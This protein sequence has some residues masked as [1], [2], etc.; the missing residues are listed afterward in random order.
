ML[1][2]S[3]INGMESRQLDVDDKERERQKMAG[4]RGPLSTIQHWFWCRK[5]SVLAFSV[6]VQLQ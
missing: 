5:A 4:R 1:A 3:G 6:K 2:A